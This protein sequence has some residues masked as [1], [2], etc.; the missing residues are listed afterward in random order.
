MK[1]MGSA[2]RRLGPG[3][4]APATHLPREA[5]G[6]AQILRRAHLARHQIE[7]Y[8]QTS[9]A[10]QQQDDESYRDLCCRFRTAD[11]ELMR[12]RPRA[13][14][15]RGKREDHR[16]DREDRQNSNR[17]Q[18]SSATEQESHRDDR[19]QLTESAEDRRTKPRV[20]LP[21]VFQKSEAVSPAPSRRGQWLP[22]SPRVSRRSARQRRRD[23]VPEQTD[24]PR[25]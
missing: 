4:C 8:G 1:K 17:C 7:G 9:E 22:L 11:D 12:S 3:S 18:S 23:Q 16:H 24:Q 15:C 14:A 13:Q 19:A 25:D 10:D 2:N 20:Q 21:V 6:G 5:L